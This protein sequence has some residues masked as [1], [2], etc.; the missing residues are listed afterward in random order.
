MTKKCWSICRNE[1]CARVCVCTHV[2]K[3][4]FNLHIYIK[5][6]YGGIIK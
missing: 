6:E 3:H 5:L 1:V 4:I 2:H